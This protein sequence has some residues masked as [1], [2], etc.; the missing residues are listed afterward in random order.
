MDVADQASMIRLVGHSGV[1]DRRAQTFV[2][3]QIEGGGDSLNGC[4]KTFAV[5]ANLRRGGKASDSFI[6]SNNRIQDV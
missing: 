1:F 3:V 2:D 6:S 5:G 4:P